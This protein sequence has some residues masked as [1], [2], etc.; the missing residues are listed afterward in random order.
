V[1]PHSSTPAAAEPTNDA[2]RSQ[3][4]ATTDAAQ[5]ESPSGDSGEIEVPEVK[6]EARR[7]AVETEITDAGLT[8]RTSNALRRAG[9]L[10]LNDVAAHSL[11]ELAAI[12][13]L[14]A[15][16]LDELSRALADHGFA[17]RGQ[18]PA[19]AHAH[20]RGEPTVGFAR[21]S[22]RARNALVRLR[23]ETMEDLAA[24]RRSDVA[25]APQV[26]SNTV[27]ELEQLLGSAGR[28]F[29]P[30]PA[31]PHERRQDSRV[32]DMVRLRDEGATLDEIGKAY[33]LTRERVRQL[34]KSAGH[35]GAIARE[36]VAA[37]RER[38]AQER[39]ADVLAAYRRGD[40]TA[41]IAQQL[42]LHP[43]AVRDLLKVSVTPRD[44]AARRGTRRNWHQ[45]HYSDDDLVDAVR[46]V[47]E[48]YGRT[49]TTEEYERAAAGGMLPTELTI[50]NRI[51]WVVALERAGYPPPIRKRAYTRRFPEATC[52]HA[53]RRLVIESGHIPTHAEYEALAQLDDR[54]PAAAT[55]RNRVGRWT[56]ITAELARLPPRDDVLART[57][58]DGDGLPTSSDIWLAYLDETLHI[59]D[60]IVALITGDLIWDHDEFGP[61]PSEL[62][63]TVAEVERETTNET[64]G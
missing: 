3:A 4:G 40:S 44:G 27:R 34:L 59:E 32:A 31:R 14:G 51:G 35:T 23:V 11:E 18:P 57:P 41:E 15:K 37:K 9:L 17:P 5:S 1:S 16:S 48:R 64:H 21:L 26:G 30:E 28:E 29:A 38:A 42:D 53:L 24:L 49:P 19:D 12:P 20:N 25:A 2:M 22:V 54:L 47:A 33:D 52:R 39:L 36:N 61:P 58:S 45:Q 55:V 60:V 50:R 63:D 62:A 13:N 46:E 10:T 8:P 7:F 56:A 43:A 6:S